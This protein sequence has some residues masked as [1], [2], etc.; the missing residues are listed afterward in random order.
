M[1]DTDSSSTKKRQRRTSP[2]DPR[3]ND[4]DF[5][6]PELPV[7]CGSAKGTLYRE[8]FKKGTHEKSIRSETGE[9]LT[10]RKFE[11][12]GDHEKSK[13]WKKSIQC[14]GWTLGYLIE[15]GSLP[16]PPMMKE[17]ARRP[18]MC[19]NDNRVHERATQGY[20]GSTPSVLHTTE[21]RGLSRPPGAHADKQNQEQA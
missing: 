20:A 21:E 6:L 3:Q 15:K 17:K 4:V 10:L 1:S 13:N 16:N 2:R 7:T 19:G 12:R 18:G 9:W 5:N 14:F 11:I 8:I